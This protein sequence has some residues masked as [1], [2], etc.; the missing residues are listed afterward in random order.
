MANALGTV[1]G[2]LILQRALQLV[3]T[4]RPILRN[5]A[6]NFRDLDTGA[7]EA[8]W[9]QPVYARILAIPA[10]QDF[11]AAAID[12]ADTDVPVTMT[13]FKQILQSFT[14][15]QYSST[16]RDL[17]DESAEPIAVAFANHMVDA[18]SANWTAANFPYA[19][20]KPGGWD[21]EHLNATRAAL[22][23]RGVPDGQRRFFSADLQVYQAFLQDTLIVA[24]LNNPNNA[25]AI[26]SG[27]LP[28]VAGF[29]IDEYPDIPNV[30][31]LVG[32]AGTPDSVVYAQRVPKNPN[33]LM[34]GVQFPGNLAI[35]TD[36]TTGLSVMVTQWIDP[37]T[38][39]ANTRIIWM[40]GTA[41]GNSNNGQRI[42][43]G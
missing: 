37:S 27:K 28:Q 33:E 3:F 26:M 35:I 29:G 6:L 4:K 38:L 18:V 40:Y 1:A 10:V 8:K 31:N 16:D 9:N 25:G 7:V 5:I 20:I 17:I 24:A 15:Q 19:T 41:V 22:S 39:L 12:R 43:T 11:G 42:V 2:A 36:P 13:Q 34:P 21:Y 32:F 14:P 23:G 30:G